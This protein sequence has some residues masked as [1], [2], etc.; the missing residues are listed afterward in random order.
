MFK[1]ISNVNTF[2][3][4]KCATLVSEVLK[5]MLKVIY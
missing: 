5:M 3:E 4:K 2:A 1:L